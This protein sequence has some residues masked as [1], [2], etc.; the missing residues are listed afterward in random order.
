MTRIGMFMVKLPGSW[1]V[2]G[3]SYRNCSNHCHF[4]DVPNKTVYVNCVTYDNG[5]ELFWLG[6]SFVRQ[7]VCWCIDMQIQNCTLQIRLWANAFRPGLSDIK[8]CPTIKYGQTM[9]IFI[10]FTNSVYSLNIKVTN[11][12]H[13]LDEIICTWWIFKIPF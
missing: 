10:Q 12:V 8:H 5:L 3:Y 4:Y 6:P 13:I 9:L 11:S 7:W 2:L 1:P